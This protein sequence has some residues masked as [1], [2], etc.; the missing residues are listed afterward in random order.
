MNGRT[1]PEESKRCTSRR[2]LGRGLLTPAGFMRTQQSVRKRPVSADTEGSVD[3]HH[4]VSHKSQYTHSEPGHGMTKWVVLLVCIVIH[5]SPKPFHN[6]CRRISGI[7]PPSQTRWL[8]N[9]DPREIIMNRGVDGGGGGGGLKIDI[10]RFTH[11]S[12]A[13][14]QEKQKAGSIKNY[15]FINKHIAIFYVQYVLWTL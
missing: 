6:L 5:F 3:I 14:S 4:S 2:G 8:S 10:K 1:L 9:N 7:Q 15:V 12:V 13:L 11:Q